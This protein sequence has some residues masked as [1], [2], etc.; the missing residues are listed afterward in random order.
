MTRFQSL[1]FAILTTTCGA[2]AGAEPP[3]FEDDE[4]TRGTAQPWRSEEMPSLFSKS[5]TTVSTTFYSRN[6]HATD[7][8]GDIHVNALSLGIDWRSGYAAGPWGFVGA[9]VSGFTNLRVAP[10]TGLSEVLYHDYRDDADKTYA[11]LAHA[12]LKWRSTATGD[13]WQVRAGYTPLSVGTLGSSGGLHSHAYRGAEVKYHVAGWEF[14]YALADQFRNEWDNRFRPMTNAWHQNRDQYDGTASR[15]DYVHSAGIRYEAAADTY[16]DGGVGEGKRYRRN[17]Q[18]A[19]TR[20]WRTGEHG[21]VT[22]TGYAL[23]G[24]YQAA[25][26]PVASPANEWHASTSVGYASGPFTVSMGFGVTHAPDSRE[27]NFRLTPWANS[28]NRNQ[29]QTWGQLDD[30]VWDGARVIKA[31]ASYQIGPYIGVPGLAV[32]VSGIRG[33][34]IKNP[35]RGDTSANEIDLSVTYDVKEGPL[36]GAG[37]GVFPARLRTNGFYGKSDRNDVKIIAS[38]SKTF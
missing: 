5:E 12:A 37:I 8:A 23:W 14:G 13:G 19:A 4:L 7:H 6:R 24:R 1:C 18:V 29:I 11:T 22:T 20:A 38:Y 10:G 16:V 33:W 27:M 21:T 26:G 35:G 34:A 30:F 28:D 15:I 36:K 31:S 3:A 25:L 32:G 9:D 17:A 2:S